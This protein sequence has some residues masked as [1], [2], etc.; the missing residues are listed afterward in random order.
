MKKLY[1]YGEGSIEKSVCELR[2]ISEKYD[3]EIKIIE[4]KPP[5]DYTLFKDRFMKVD[6][7]IYYNDLEIRMFFEDYADVFNYFLLYLFKINSNPFTKMALRNS[8]NLSWLEYV[9]S[10]RK[11]HVHNESLTELCTY[12]SLAVYIINTKRV[13]ILKEMEYSKIGSCLSMLVYSI[14]LSNPQM[15]ITGLVNEAIH[16]E[17]KFDLNEVPA[18]EFSN[19]MI[20]ECLLN[21]FNPKRV[22]YLID[23]RRQT[24][25]IGGEI[26]SSLSIKDLSIFSRPSEVLGKIEEDISGNTN[27]V[28]FEVVDLDLKLKDVN[29]SD[30]HKHL[31]DVKN[32]LGKYFKNSTSCTWLTNYRYVLYLMFQDIGDG[33]RYF[34]DCLVYEFYDRMKIA[35]CMALRRSESVFYNIVL[36]YKAFE[37]EGE[38]ERKIKESQAKIR[39]EPKLFKKIHEELKNYVTLPVTNILEVKF[40]KPECVCESSKPNPC[41]VLIN[42]EGDSC[43]CESWLSLAENF[44]RREIENKMIDFEGIDRF[45]VINK[46][47]KRHPETKFSFEEICLSKVI[48]RMTD[49]ATHLKLI[50]IA[51]EVTTPAF[52]YFVFQYS[53]DKENVEYEDGTGIKGGTGEKNISDEI[54]DEEEISNEYD[55]QGNVEEDDGVDFDNQGSISTCDEDEA[56]Q[57]GVEGDEEKEEEKDDQQEDEKKKDELQQSE[58]EDNFNEVEDFEETKDEEMLLEEENPEKDEMPLDD[59]KTLDDEMPADEH[60]SQ[61]VENE[62]T[63]K[64]QALNNNQSC[65]NAED[66]ERKVF[67]E[68]VEEEALCEG[69]GEEQI[70]G[71]EETGEA[72]GEMATVN[73]NYRDSSSHS[74]TLLLRSIFESNRYNKY[75]GDYKSGKKLNMKKIIPYI[76]SDYQKDKI[77]MKRR[78]SDKKDYVVRLFVDN[79]RS[80]YSQS[81]VDTLFV[82]FSRLSNSFQ[83]LGIPV[84]IYKFG[85]ELVECTIKEMTFSDTETNIDWIDQFKDG[86]N[87]VLTDGVFQNTSFYNN[88]FLIILIDRSGI[89]K[90]SKVSVCEGNIF[91][92]K[93]LDQFQLKYCTIEKVEELENTFI[94]ALSEL[95][96]NTNE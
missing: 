72:Y 65:S 2:D 90:M 93:Y 70:V 4:D 67:G 16:C 77:W 69:E 23:N 53:E 8:L 66:Y 18:L 94:L 3:N 44:N 26:A 58:Q 31:L 47:Y 56:S 21:I 52:L 92:Q 9:S 6:F 63:Y 57:T 89:K 83:A 32:E 82:T 7:E 15:N 91:V 1:K 30:T 41:L 11:L 19:E 55:D 45:D 24:V 64:E 12:E 84:E 39:K 81:M 25:C 51:L 61:G 76:A 80:M 59:A 95:I 34:L 48:S 33:Q 62:Y 60:Q 38:V 17:D 13:D 49:D 43:G 50:N 68:N 20:N 86:I 5:R 74:L 88:N 29:L 85:N 37:I 40:S 27:L 46:F 42:K 96:K 22:A 36:Q 14:L 79:S 35:E 28:S 54:K 87:I 10:L 75:K 73:I 71:N 78:K